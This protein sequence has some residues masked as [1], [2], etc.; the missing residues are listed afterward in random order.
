MILMNAE[1]TNSITLLQEK[2]FKT[3]P[4]KLVA[5]NFSSSGAFDNMNIHQCVVLKSAFNL[6]L[7]IPFTHFFLSLNQQTCLLTTVS[8]RS[9]LNDSHCVLALPVHLCLF[10][11]LLANWSTSAF[12][13]HP[14]QEEKKTF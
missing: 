4:K 3:P 10:V 5:L 7:L 13:I 9:V 1:L 12:S 14:T 11:C 2:N 6:L 8:P